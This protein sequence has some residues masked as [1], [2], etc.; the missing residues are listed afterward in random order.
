MKVIIDTNVFISGIFYK[1]PPHQILQAWRDSK[2]TI[3]MS[4]EILEEYNRVANRIS[5]KFPDINISG[6]MD[7]LTVKARI[8]F[9]AELP[10]QITT[11]LDDEKFIACALAR[12]LSILS[13]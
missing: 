6:V 10:E 7:L 1:G 5:D 13:A 11:D 9:Q 4:N 8:V 12:K 2:I 3:V